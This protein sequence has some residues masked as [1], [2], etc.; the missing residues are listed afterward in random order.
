MNLT[1]GV[2]KEGANQPITT[3][4]KALDKYLQIENIMRDILSEIR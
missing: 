2:I 4:R 1:E 3:D